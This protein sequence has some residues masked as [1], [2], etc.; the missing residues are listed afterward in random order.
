MHQVINVVPIRLAEIP[1]LDV[2]AAGLT[3]PAPTILLQHGWSGRKETQVVTAQALSCAGFRVLVPD[4]NGHGDR[5]AFPAYDAPEASRHFWS[6]LEAQ[7]ADFGRLADA[8]VSAGLTDP[9]RIGVTGNS[10]G[11]MIAAGATA[12]Y[13]WAKVAAVM[14]GSGC[15]SHTFQEFVE[16]IPHGADPGAEAKARVLAIDPE[17]QIG[18]IAPRPVL[19]IHGER[20]TVVPVTGVQRFAELARPYYAACPERLRLT[21]I[22]RLDHH[23]T[24][25]MVDEVRA[26]FHQYL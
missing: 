23:V 2:H 4:A 18:R 20:D 22:P 14:N 7:I 17:G 26:W 1:V 15:F 3:G 13:S 19:L 8:A 11:G 12:R 21:V 24:V 5:D 25:G 16:M 9:D 10:M 6:V